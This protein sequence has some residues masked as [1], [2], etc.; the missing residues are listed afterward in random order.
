MVTSCRDAG[1]LI[2]ESIDRLRDAGIERPQLEAELLVALAFGISRL[3]TLSHP[4]V[5]ADARIRQRWEALVKRREAR[6]PLAYLRGS[7]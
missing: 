7:Q 6:E 3:E 5:E 1:S 4:A 2:R